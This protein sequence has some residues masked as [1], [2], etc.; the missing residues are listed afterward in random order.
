MCSYDRQTNCVILLFLNLMLLFKLK[1]RLGP[2]PQPWYMLMEGQVEIIFK[3]YN[4]LKS[5]S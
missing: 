1:I 2:M 4:Y 5:I 3:K